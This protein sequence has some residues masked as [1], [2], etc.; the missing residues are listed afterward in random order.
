MSSVEQE[1]NL[2]RILGFNPNEAGIYTPSG[3]TIPSAEG[4]PNL[5][6][7]GDEQSEKFDDLFFRATILPSV[8]IG[9]NTR[10]AYLPSERFTVIDDGNREVS[11]RYHFVDPD[12]SLHQQQF[13]IESLAVFR[14]IVDG[15]GYATGTPY[16][17]SR[18]I[19]KEIKG[20]TEEEVT[21]YKDGEVEITLKGGVWGDSTAFVYE[22][23]KLKFGKYSHP[24]YFKRID[25]FDSQKQ[26][27][28]MPG[29]GATISLPN[30]LTHALPTEL[31]VRDFSLEESPFDSPPYRDELWKSTKISEAFGI[32]VK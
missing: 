27:A 15:H 13:P 20:Q 19:Q 8:G 14:R 5:A 23:G 16:R 17:L 31:F 26:L 9:E 2:I 32:R 12:K 30:Y 28:T 7:P 1:Q 25:Y 10:Y 29:M 6:T 22:E 3:L 21:F 4:L 24:D 18:I 11:R